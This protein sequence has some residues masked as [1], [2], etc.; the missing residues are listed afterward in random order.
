[1]IILIHIVTRRNAET[2]KEMSVQREVL[3]NITTHQKM[4]QQSLSE[5]LCV[6]I[7]RT[8]RLVVLCMTLF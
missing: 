3:V 4:Y 1:M 6:M 8:K 7:T 5:I 2:I